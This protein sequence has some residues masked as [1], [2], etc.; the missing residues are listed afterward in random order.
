[1]LKPLRQKLIGADVRMKSN[2]RRAKWRRGTPLTMSV[3]E[4]GW[5]YF[6][7]CENASYAA[8]ERGDIPYIS[9]G[10]RKRVPIHLMDEKLRLAGSISASD[11]AAA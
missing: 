6:G 11:E 5:L 7:L 10:S 3:P 9:V 1:M 8:A 2:E 4:A